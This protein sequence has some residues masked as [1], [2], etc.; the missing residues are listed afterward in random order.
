MKLDKYIVLRSENL[1]SKPV[2][3]DFGDLAM[4]SGVP[5]IAAF[6]EG[7]RANH[8]TEPEILQIEEAELSTKERNEL[9]RDPHTKG[10]AQAMPLQLIE[11]MDKKNITN[12]SESLDVW[13][14]DAVKAS[15]SSYD[16]R[17]ITVAVLDTGI[18]PNHPAFSGMNLIQENFTSESDDDIHGH[19]THCAGTIFG[20]DVDGLRIG[21]ARGVEY[22]LIGKVLGQGGNTT[23][24]ISKAINWA[25][26]GGANVISMSLGIDFPKFVEINKEVYG[27]DIKVATSKAL[28]AYRANINLFN[29]LAKQAKAYSMFGQGC[30]IVAASGNESRRP[31]YSIAA[32]PPAASE[33]IISV[34]ALQKKPGGLDVADFSNTQVDIAAPGQD[35][36]S[37]DH[38]GGLITMSGTS[39]A[40]P[41]VAGIAALWA[42]KALEETGK[43]EYG[44]LKAKLI[45][46][47]ITKGL[48]DQISEDDIGTGL[49][50]APIE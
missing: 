10:I 26:Q 41:Y 7:K 25:I 48:T 2:M 50:Q 44:S 47:G 17:G 31:Q 35:I 23:V 6:G 4:P 5:N 49:V 13:G 18:N 27:F 20:R 36:I 37:A 29:L 28:E 12:S 30:I 43:I 8:E 38:T 33:E 34:G 22:A 32:A 1:P 40:T 46:S 14:L 24:D 16:G 42:Q 45:A 19:G 9:K 21:V 3:P 39:M 15:Q 11:P